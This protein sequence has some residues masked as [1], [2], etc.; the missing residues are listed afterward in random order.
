[1]SE[2]RVLRVL[3]TIADL[4]TL[5]AL[6]VAGVGQFLPWM[7]T[8]SLPKVPVAGLVG[9]G[10]SQAADSM[11]EFQMWH[12][13]RSGPALAAAAVLVCLSLVFNPR[14]LARKILVSLMFAAVFT[15]ACFETM[16]YSPMP[17]TPM[18]SEFGGIGRMEL[19]GFFVALVPT[20]IAGLLCLV[21][22]VWTM[23]IP[24]RPAAQAE[25]PRRDQ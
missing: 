21:R 8:L 16:I 14:G 19:P 2:R 25:I 7:R 13:M 5:L 18:H 1:M 23:A 11:I 24:A 6:A 22:M 17:I 4:L 9:L 20:I 15:A 12:V 10:G 3:D